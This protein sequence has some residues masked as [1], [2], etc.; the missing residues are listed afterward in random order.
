M[1]TGGVI[2]GGGPGGRKPRVRE[3]RSMP[4]ASFYQDP[5]LSVVSTVSVYLVVNA[6]G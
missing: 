1:D 3:I 4:S 5:K 2:G 6:S